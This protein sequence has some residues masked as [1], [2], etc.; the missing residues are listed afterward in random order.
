MTRGSCLCGEVTWE[1]RSALEFMSHCHCSMCRKSHGA[2]VG[3]YAMSD[4]NGFEWLS[5]EDVIVHYESSPGFFRPFCGRCGSV[6]AGA[7]TD[8]KMGFPVG[9]LEGDFEERP[10][11]HIFVADKAAWHEIH[12]DLPCFDAY[13]PGF[14][15]PDVP[16][17][18]EGGS[19]D[20]PVRGSCLCGAV[21]YAIEGTIPLFLNCH[22]QRCRK[23]RSAPHATNGFIEAGQF[24][25][26]AGEE[27]LRRFKVPDADR[28]TQVFCEDCGSIMPI[29]REGAERVVIPAGSLDNDPGGRERAHIFCGSKSHWYEI[30]DKLEQFDEYPTSPLS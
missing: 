21:A 2:A 17:R 27:K 29:T 8:G 7:S 23:G 13:P 20:D 25:W 24:R 14:D 9:T 12:G 10:V 19:P 6:V 11:A 1:I 3:C 4:G 28:F 18:A 30:S 26:I 5:G 16:A 15:S 22:C